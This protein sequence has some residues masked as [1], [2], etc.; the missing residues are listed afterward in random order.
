LLLQAAVDTLIERGV[1][2][3]TTLE[4]QQ[5][6]G[7]SR[8]NLLHHFATRAD[9]L[10]ATVAELV[11]RNEADLWREYERTDKALDPL[12][13]AIRTLIAAG[14]SPSSVAELELWAV[15]RTDAALRAM[16]RDAERRA[17]KERERV[18][19][20]LFAA[21][22]SRPGCALVVSLSIEFGRGIALSDVLRADPSSRD[23]LVEGWIAAARTIIDRR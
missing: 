13:A 4:V 23:Q 16:L 9:L 18:M 19:A 7:V 2:C 11:K 22:A 8:G 12:A 3:T 1:A 21:V 17:L 5:R 14:S 6:A 20:A 15:A 10:A